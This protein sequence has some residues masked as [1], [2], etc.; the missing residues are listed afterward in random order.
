MESEDILTKYGWHVLNSAQTNSII[1]DGTF[2]NTE[3]N[4][5]KIAASMLIGIDPTNYKNN[6][7]III[8]HVLFEQ[9]P[10]ANLR[11]EAWLYNNKVICIYI[12][13]AE[14][15][16]VLNY[17]ALDTEMTEINEFFDDSLIVN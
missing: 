8:Q 7:I 5:K 4:Q 14:P 1:M 16:V 3:I 13:H 17:W 10:T 11:A 15:N 2:I 6:S 9:G 12:F